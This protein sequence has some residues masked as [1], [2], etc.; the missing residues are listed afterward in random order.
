VRSSIQKQVKCILFAERRDPKVGFWAGIESKEELVGKPLAVS[1]GHRLPALCAGDP[2]AHPIQQKRA[3]FATLA[4]CERHV[5]ATPSHW[6]PLRGY[7]KQ[8]TSIE[9]TILAF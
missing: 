7:L 2:R 3:Q 9:V 4:R 5:S 1:P 8:K 6:I